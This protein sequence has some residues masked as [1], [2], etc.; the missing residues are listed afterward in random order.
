MN[1]VLYS[2]KS[3]LV[4]FR[5]SWISSELSLSVST[6]TFLPKLET[7]VYFIEPRMSHDWNHA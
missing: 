6:A 5:L 2:R 1:L 4:I 3:W 7:S